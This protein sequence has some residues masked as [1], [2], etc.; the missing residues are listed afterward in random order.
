M[1]FKQMAGV[2]RRITVST[3]FCLR[4]VLTIV[5]LLVQDR[6]HLMLWAAILAQLWVQC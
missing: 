6:S 5:C 4:Y 3:V 1:A 2:T